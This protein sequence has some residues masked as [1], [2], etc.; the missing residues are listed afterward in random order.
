[1]KL[2]LKALLALHL[3]LFT[4]HHS[5]FGASPPPPNIIII[6]ADDLGYGDTGCYG[7]TH[8]RTPNID[9]LALE[10]RRFT[11]AHS[12]SA[13]C[14]SSRYG[15][16]TGRYPHRENFWGPISPTHKLTIN[17][18]L[19]T[20]PNLLQNA[21]YD[22]AIIGKWHLGF[23]DEKPNWNGDLKPGP[24]EIGF[25][26]YFGIPAVNSGPPFVYVENHRIIGLDPNDPIVF[27]KESVTKKIPEKSGY[28]RVGGA[29]AAHRLYIDDQIGTTFAK[30]AV[31]WIQERDQDTPFFLYLATTNI[32]H[33][34]TPA[35]QFVGTSDCGLYGDFIHE[36]DW[37]V[38]QV[39][40]A[41]DERNLTDNTLV[42]F[43]SDNG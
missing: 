26:S 14:S 12:T 43:T 19:T 13:V 16:L 4:I 7:A 36:L 9:R 24:L 29:D 8:I 1:M 40:T 37:I 11:D 35:P 23:G 39:L 6:N 32:H 34:F 42:I 27:G 15:L 2:H 20:I 25:D 18:R 30:R 41:L 10:G 22:T 33:P 17:P 3:S 5:L 21:G 38:G 31:K 28:D